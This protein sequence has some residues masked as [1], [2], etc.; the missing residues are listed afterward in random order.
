V[1]R[2]QGKYAGAGGAGVEAEGNIKSALIDSQ[3]TR[4]RLVYR[5]DFTKPTGW[6]EEHS[7]HV[8]VVRYDGYYHIA[9]FRPGQLKNCYAYFYPS[10]NME[11][12]FLAKVDVGIKR[13]SGKRTVCGLA[14]DIH[15][16]KE[17]EKW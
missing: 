11:N 9:V 12:N 3:T 8:S 13:E 4:M 2:T 10:I 1:S 14:F 6:D 15:E 17:N 5:S 7:T 16:S